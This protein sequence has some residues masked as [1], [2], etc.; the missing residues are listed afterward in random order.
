MIGDDLNGGDRKAV[1]AGLAE[2]DES[3]TVKANFNSTASEL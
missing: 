1:R 2:E 3:K